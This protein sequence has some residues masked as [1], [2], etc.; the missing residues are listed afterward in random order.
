MSPSFHRHLPPP[1]AFAD[2]LNLI[3]PSFSK[4]APALDPDEDPI[5]Q[6]RHTRHLAKYIFPGQYGLSTPFKYVA[7]RKAYVYPN[8]LDRELDIKVSARL[9]ASLLI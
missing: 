7:A 3:H 9:L 2:I 5:G 1:H 4:A 6:A 8:Y